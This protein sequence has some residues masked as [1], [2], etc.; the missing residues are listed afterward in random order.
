MDRILRDDSPLVIRASRGVG[1]TVVAQQLAGD[2]THPHRAIVYDCFG[3]GSYRNPNE[4]RHPTKVA[5]VQIANEL[6]RDGLC[7]PLI[8]RPHDGDHTLFAAFKD[9]LFQAITIL[10]QRDPAARLILIIDA[11]DNSEMAAEEREEKGFAKLLFR[12]DLPV[13]CKLVAFSRPSNLKKKC[14][15]VMQSQVTSVCRGLATLPPCIPKEVLASA[16]KLESSDI[17]SFVADLG[18]PLWISDN[19]VYFRDEPT[20]SWFRDTF[21]AETGQISDMV[22]DLMPLSET[23]TYVARA[24]P[25]LLHQAKKSDELLALALSDRGL[26]RNAGAAEVKE[27]TIQRTQFAFKAALRGNR[28]L[29]ATKLA[30][31]AAEE[32]AGTERVDELLQRNADFI[33]SCLSPAATQEL[34]LSRRLSVGWTGSSNIYTALLLSAHGDFRGQALS[35][36]RSSRNWLETFMEQVRKRPKDTDHPFD[37]GPSLGLDELAAMAGAILNLEGIESTVDFLVA[38]KPKQ[39]IYEITA[40]LAKSLV[41]TGRINDVRALMEEAHEE[42]HI[43]VGCCEHL[44][45]ACIVPDAGSLGFTLQF[46]S[47]ST[48]LIEMPG[49]DNL[50]QQRR[51]LPLVALCEAASANDLDRTQVLEILRK[52]C[53]RSN[54]RNVSYYRPEPRTTFFRAHSL[55]MTLSGQCDFKDTEIWKA[56]SK[57]AEDRANSRRD[58]LPKL[59]GEYLFPWYLRRAQTLVGQPG[60]EKIH[61]T[62]TGRELAYK[63]HD[64]HL[65]GY[66]V[67]CV[68]VEVLGFSKAVTESEFS[69][70]RSR[71]LEKPGERL[72]IVDTIHLARII[73]RHEHLSPIGDEIEEFFHRFVREVDGE[74]DGENSDDQVCFAK[75]IFPIS[76]P[77]A[78]AHFGR[79][80]EATSKFGHKL[81]ERWSAILAVATRGASNEVVHQDLCQRYFRSAE[82]VAGGVASSLSDLETSLSE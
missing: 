4:P 26:P 17:D 15:E 1:K 16:A 75:A 31:K 61:Q 50:D 59:F 11:A 63:D 38:W 73:Y 71:L 57:E 6:A 2:L 48:D 23:S 24:L 76:K 45:G 65:I 18:R 36:L 5:L 30:F 22:E 54:L 19:L 79:A 41:D 7:S 25:S 21:A 60:S 13:G 53:D 68:W 81:N 58:E 77:D 37:Q 3:N 14:P 72:R 42:P 52:V 67:A 47:Q 69:Q 51:H 32:M 12:E 10:R 28:L 62:P 55:R 49:I 39:C 80:I 29:D 70:F 46:L 82:V 27:I 56:I 43:V 40:R 8:P 74:P 44:I 20:E 33:G 66:E 9:R 78:E 64:A 35:F 34:A